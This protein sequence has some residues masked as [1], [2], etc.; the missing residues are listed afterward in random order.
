MDAAQ[1]D[2]LDYIQQHLVVQCFYGPCSCQTVAALLQAKLYD[3]HIHPTR[4][5]RQ[6]QHVLKWCPEVS[7]QLGT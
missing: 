2:L 6:Y 4:L 5:V 1:Q 3:S 7:S